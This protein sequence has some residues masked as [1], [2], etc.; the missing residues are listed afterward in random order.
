VIAPPNT[1]LNLGSSHIAEFRVINKGKLDSIIG[2][3][4]TAYSIDVQG[5]WVNRAGI[6]PSAP[7]LFPAGGEVLVR[8]PMQIPSALPGG[9]GVTQLKVT[10]R[11]VANNRLVDTGVTLVTAGSA[12][13]A[14]SAAASAASVMQGKPVTH[15]ITVRNLSVDAAQDVTVR[16]TGLPDTATVATVSV[17]QGVCEGLTHILCRLGTLTPNGEAVASLTLI[18][19]AAGDLL[20]EISVAAKTLDPDETN[21]SALLAIRVM[22][23]PR[24]SVQPVTT[25]G[26]SVTTG[27][28]YSARW[29]DVSALQFD[30]RYDRNLF[31]IAPSLGISAYA[32]G[33]TMVSAVL[34]NGDTRVLIFGMNQT[35]IGDGSVVNL[36]ISVAANAAAG[37]YPIDLLNVVMSDPE[38]NGVPIEV[39]SGQ[40]II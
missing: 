13:L 37:I 26:E 29:A 35:S 14:V 16:V 36:A 20:N 2:Q 17:S 9:S 25:T 5:N 10:V 3:S 8:V 6:T 21:N 34:P 4:G 23:V 30:L 12:D 24:L 28:M 18:P 38:G 39:L 40:I 15:T 31:H 32:A 33:K 19:A 22:G 1:S 11:K 27:I 7:Q